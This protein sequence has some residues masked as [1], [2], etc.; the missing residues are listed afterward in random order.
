MAQAHGIYGSALN[1]CTVIG[2]PLGYSCTGVKEKET[3]KALE[4][5][6][7]E[8]DAVIDL[9]D[10]KN[11]DYCFVTQEMSR[12]KKI[13]GEKILKV[14]VETCFLTE[15]E[16]IRMCR[17]VTE[18]GA[19]FI[20]TST[21]FGSKGAQLEDIRLFREHIGPGVRIKA[22]GGIRTR[23]AMEQFL[24]AGC[25]RIGASSIDQIF[26]GGEAKKP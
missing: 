9:C 10:V 7:N 14:I 26:E 2:F 20:K 1:I 15:D 16:K 3:E 6:A 4:D 12:L 25:S 5:G 17:C 8:C 22:A 21:G 18:A 13:C 19:D 24:A 23:E 11:Q